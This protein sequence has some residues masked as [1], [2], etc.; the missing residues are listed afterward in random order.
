M[1]A[2]FPRAALVPLAL[3][4][5]IGCA[6]GTEG[7][8]NSGRLRGDPANEKAAFNPGADPHRGVGG[9]VCK[10]ENATMHGTSEDDRIRGTR[11]RDVIAALGGNDTIRGRAGDDLI[12]AGAGSDEVHGNRGRDRIYGEGGRDEVRGDRGKD[13][14][15]GSGGDDRVVG[16]KAADYL[17]GG[18]G[19]DLCA[20][21][22]PS[23][24]SG[25]QFDQAELSCEEIHG[26]AGVGGG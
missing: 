24:D 16:G 6:G 20:G 3:V 21:G 26:A 23:S 22:K 13:V 17:A 15:Y 19:Y 9:W 7:E 12:C 5:L 1:R 25:R 11:G 10:R 4:F 2:L 18:R 14:L 8:G